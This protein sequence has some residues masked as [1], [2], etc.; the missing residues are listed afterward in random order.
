[1]CVCS[2]TL[3]M[4]PWG[5]WSVCAGFGWCHNTPRWQGQC[6]QAWIS[7]AQSSATSPLTAWSTTDPHHDS[8][9][10]TRTGCSLGRHSQ[11]LG[12]HREW[13]LEYNFC[14]KMDTKETDNCSKERKSR[15]IMLNSS[16]HYNLI[17]WRNHTLKCLKMQSGIFYCFL[18]KKMTII[19]CTNKCCW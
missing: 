19:L 1:M 12:K 11:T 3:Q 8:K 6:Q 4:Q 16:L 9:G 17:S 7:T 18:A 2:R 14:Q 15:F 13:E 10:C 5:Q